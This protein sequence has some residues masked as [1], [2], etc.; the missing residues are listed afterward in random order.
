MRDAR[1]TAFL[2]VTLALFLSSV[3][4]PAAVPGYRH[5]VVVQVSNK[6]P[7]SWGLT[8]LNI[9][10]IQEQLGQNRL[11]IEVVAFGPGVYMLTRN[12]V[13]REGLRRAMQHGV[14]F[15]ACETSMRARRIMRKDMYPGVTF[16]P[17]GIAEI[18][19]KQREGWSYLKP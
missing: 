4:S 15:V 11:P 5:G 2:I 16:V 13:V 14:R 19:T 12:S 7:E 1:K 8:L 10:Y 18:I 3:P 6:D 9:K 17:L